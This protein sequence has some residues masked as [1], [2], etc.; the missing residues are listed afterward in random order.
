MPNQQEWERREYSRN[1]KCKMDEICGHG[2]KHP[3]GWYPSTQNEDYI[4]VSKMHHYTKSSLQ[5]LYVLVEKR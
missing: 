3:N 1:A 2:W 5:L 4:E